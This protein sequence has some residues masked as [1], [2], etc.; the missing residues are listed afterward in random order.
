MRQPPGC[1]RAALRCRV[2]PRGRASSRRSLGS[3]VERYATSPQF[4]TWGSKGQGGR[5]SAWRPT[6][7]REAPHA[8]YTQSCGAACSRVASTAWLRCWRRV[9]QR[10]RGG[11]APCRAVRHRLQRPTASAHAPRAQAPRAAWPGGGAARRARHGE[12]VAPGKASRAARGA[13]RRH[14]SLQRRRAG[15]PGSPPAPWRTT[16]PGQGAQR[17]W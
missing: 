5:V 16:G 7:I 10:A 8:A 14:C 9:M 3:S 13:E 1:E 15:P 2:W 17:L 12:A 11:D 6:C 4:I